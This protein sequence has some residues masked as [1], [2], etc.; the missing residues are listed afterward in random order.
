MAL[1]WDT[2]LKEDNDSFVGSI[3]MT[4]HVVVEKDKEADRYCAL[5][6][7][8]PGCATIGATPQEA[9]ENM[10]QTIQDWLIKDNC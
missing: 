4:V 9:L 7:D 1:K 5:T 10:R 3:N 8:L 6:P 2:V